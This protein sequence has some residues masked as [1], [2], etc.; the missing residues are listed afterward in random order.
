MELCDLQANC[1]LQSKVKIRILKIFGN[2]IK[3]FK[4]SL[5]S[6]YYLEARMFTN[7]HFLLSMQEN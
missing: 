5:E 7:Q 3:I 2:Y 6:Y 4:C 1:F